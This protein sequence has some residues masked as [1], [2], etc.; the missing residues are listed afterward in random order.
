MIKWT[1]EGKKEK[2]QCTADKDKA[3]RKCRMDSGVGT[4]QPCGCVL[5]AVRPKI[6]RKHTK[7][8]SSN[9]FSTPHTSLA[10]MC[11]QVSAWEPTCGVPYCSFRGIIH[12]LRSVAL[13][14]LEQSSSQRLGNGLWVRLF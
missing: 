5:V 4:G 13:P 3:E 2:L 12:L 14:A 8:T 1:V 7:L 11:Y 9:F 10:P 6:K